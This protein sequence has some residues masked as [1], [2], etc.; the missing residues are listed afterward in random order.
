VDP[1]CASG[2]AEGV[3]NSCGLHIH[4]GKSC[5]ADAMGHYYNPALPSDPWATVR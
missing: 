2:A 1:D 5:A 4:A 3:G